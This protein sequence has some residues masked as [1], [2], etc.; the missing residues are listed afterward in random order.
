MTMHDLAGFYQHSRL[1]YEKA[2]PLYAKVLEVKHRLLGPEHPETLTTMNQ[3]A[4]TYKH[5]GQHEKAEAL[6]EQVLEV[7]APR[8]RPR[9]PGRLDDDA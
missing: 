4:G 5:R 9:A 2:E 8:A 1:Q 6:Y 3:L 7:A